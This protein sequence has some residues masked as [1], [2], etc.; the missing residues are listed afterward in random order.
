[1]TTPYSAARGNKANDDRDSLH[2]F[3]TAINALLESLI[4]GVRGFDAASDKTEGDVSARMA[5]MGQTRRAHAEEI[6]RIAGDADMDPVTLDDEGTVAG[7]LHRAWIGVRDA[8]QDDDGV[9]AAAINGEQHAREEINEVVDGGLPSEVM[10]IIDRVLTSIEENLAEL[11]QM[12]A[13]H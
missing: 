13:K 11:G 2:E 3:S 10:G 6:I 12:K 5:E 8:V 7:M 9:L 4:D 1:M